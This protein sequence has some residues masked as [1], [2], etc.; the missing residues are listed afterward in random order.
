MYLYEIFSPDRSYLHPARQW[1][2]GVKLQPSL[3]S[4]A[5]TRRVR[6]H[7]HYVHTYWIEINIGCHCV[8]MPHVISNQ[9]R[10][11]ALREQSPTRSKQL[12]N[13]RERVGIR[14]MIRLKK[15]KVD[16]ETCEHSEAYDI[17]IKVPVCVSLRNTSRQVKYQVA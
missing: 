10:R 13:N 16:N 8:V 12:D 14:I 6:S 5:H 1:R 15:K 9:Y 7:T 17:A 11:S 4:W 3:P 2:F